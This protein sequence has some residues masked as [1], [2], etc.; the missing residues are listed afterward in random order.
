MRDK[1]CGE[2]T[3]DDIGKE[4]KVTGWVFRRRDHGGL[5][6]IDLRDRSGI[7]QVVFNPEISDNVHRLAHNLR[8]EFVV[9]ISGVVNK[10]PEGTENPNI[11]TGLVEIIAKGLSILNESR[12]LPFPL[13]DASQASEVLRLKYRYLDLRRPELQNN[14]VIRHKVTKAIRDY[15]DKQGFLEIETPMLT[16]STPEGARDF[17]VPSRL[18]PG[19]FYALPQSPQLFKQILMISGLERYFQIARCFRDEDLRADR[20]PEFTQVDLEM[21]FAEPDGIMTVIEG[22]LREAFK[23]IGVDIEIP[24]KRLSYREAIERFGTDKPDMRFSMELRDVGDIVSQGTFR[25]FLDAIN[26]GGRVKAINVRGLAR[27]S[28]SEIDEL[29][30]KAKNLGAKGL[31]WIKIKNGFESPIQKFFSQEIL[32]DIAER[33]EGEEGDILLFVA[34]RERVVNDVLGRLRLEFGKKLSLIKDEFNFLWVVDFPLFEWNDEEKRFESMHHPFTMP[35]PQDIE[36]LM[37][38]TESDIHDPESSISKVRALAYD[39]VLNGYEIGGG[40]IR[41]HRP[42]IQQMIFRILGISDE[43]AKEKFG[44][45]IDALSYGAPPHGGI[46]L[47]LDRLL[48]LMVGGNSIR[49]VI[50]FPKTQKAQCL[51][52]GAPSSVT[53]KQLRELYIKTL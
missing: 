24:F 19:H 22:M 7:V 23:V 44:F 21:S 52:S 18:D 12:P 15:L 41:I 31:A 35:H 40:S 32:K 14:L 27:L 13:E 42:D 9:Q 39:I 17:L 49:D 2:I 11:P 46:A 1:G 34:D 5:V 33:L 29:V 28:R 16:K 47:G 38:A 4:I 43:E 37:N 10:R 48:M 8:D 30:E 53:E 50:A 26:S 51:L 3:A 45:L 20:Q 36:I 6:F 25:V